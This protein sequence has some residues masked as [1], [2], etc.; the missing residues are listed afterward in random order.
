[1]FTKKDIKS[2]DRNYFTVFFVGCFCIV[3]Q[4]KNTKHIWS[5][6]HE[7]FGEQ[8]R[9]V[10]CHKHNEYDAYHFQRYAK[11]IDCA[12]SKIK[13]HDFYQLNGRKNVKK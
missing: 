9:C 2:I 7:E 12:I 10:I 6:N 3:L 1:M 4:S 8:K 5:I 13:E 11:N